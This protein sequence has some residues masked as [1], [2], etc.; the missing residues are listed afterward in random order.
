MAKRGDPNVL[1][2]V[3]IF[4]RALTR[5]TQV[6]FGKAS[7]I[8]QGDISRY[9]KGELAPPEASLRR[10]A[11]AANV[12]WPL[13][14]LL[15]RFIEAF[16]AAA[17]RRESQIPALDPKVLEPALLAVTPYLLE[18]TGTER[19]RPPEEERREAEEIWT[20][21]EKYP[22]PRRRRLIEYTLRA[23][24]SAALA[25]RICE[26]SAQASESNAREALELAELAFSI[27]ERVEDEES[28]GVQGHCRERLD[29][30]RRAAERNGGAAGALQP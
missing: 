8:D 20:A 6:E 3:V 23:S 22:I 25:M 17:A 10:M 24:K 27:A 4:L 26:A 29:S 21:L 2:L 1:R 19:K 18:D 7:G 15:I 14:G 13:A 11:K 9:E 5:M 12:P 16:L 28:G 30:A